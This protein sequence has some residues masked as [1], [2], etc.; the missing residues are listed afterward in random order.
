MH[1]ADGSDARADL[2]RLDAVLRDT[3]AAA[4][5]RL[6]AAWGLH[7]LFVALTGQPAADTSDNWS[8]AFEE[9]VAD[10]GLALSPYYAALCL[11]DGQRTYAFAEGARRAIRKA[12]DRHPDRPVQVLYAGTGPFAPLAVM[13]LPHFQSHEVRFTLIDIHDESD[14]ASRQVFAALRAEDMV[15]D[16]HVADATQWTPPNGRRY[17]VIISEVM[18]NALAKEPQ[19]EMTRA[20]APFLAEGGVFVPEEIRLDLVV[21]DSSTLFGEV[22]APL[23]PPIG[24]A[25][26]LTADTALAFE[27]DDDVIPLP[28]VTVPE[29][30][31]GEDPLVV[32]TKIR[33]FDDVVLDIGASG[34]TMPF[35]LHGIPKPQAGQT[36]TLGYQIG[37][38]PK[39][40]V[41]LSVA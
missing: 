23:P 34:L 37:A 27:V 31:T 10:T 40:L 21:V 32:L 14:Q 15:A 19:L 11:R 29:D 12:R 39:L 3:T 17:D 9:T 38:H 35:I 18:Q 25:M 22:P 1:E 4:I 36:M 20:L 24:H 30:V 26:T 28:A 16:R 41:S 2:A 33:T 8:A 6:H 7:D 5:D 13:Q